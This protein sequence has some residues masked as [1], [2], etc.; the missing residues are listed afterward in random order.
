V[1]EVEQQLD[2]SPGYYMT[3]DGARELD[4]A[5]FRHMGEHAAFF[6][7]VLSGKGGAYAARFLRDYQMRTVIEKLKMT[8]TTMPREVLAA[9]ITGVKLQLIMWWLDN[10]MPYPPEEM[11]RMAADLAMN[12]LRNIQPLPYA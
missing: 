2:G 8:P 9:Y 12:G 5:I 6:K 10:D 3:P 11:G 7:A 1:L 4:I